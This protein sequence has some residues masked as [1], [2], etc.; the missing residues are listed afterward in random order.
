MHILANKHVLCGQFCIW[1]A[2]AL[3][4]IMTA[5]VELPSCGGIIVE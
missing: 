5:G 3:N 4:T 1:K 2:N